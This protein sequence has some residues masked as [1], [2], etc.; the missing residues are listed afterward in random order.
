M[1]LR[2]AP[3]LHAARFSGTWKQLVVTSYVTAAISA[4]AARELVGHLPMS[5]DLLARCHEPPQAHELKQL[6]T[7]IID[8]Y[9]P[10]NLGVVV[11]ALRGFWVMLTDCVG[12]N[13]AG[14]A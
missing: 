1:G 3:I 2:A 14:P 4:S 9:D 7:A 5:A 13:P 8:P 10:I 12:R 6:V 11:L